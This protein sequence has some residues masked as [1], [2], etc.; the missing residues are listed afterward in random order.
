[1][2]LPVVCRLVDL[3]RDPQTDESLHIGWATYWA[4]SHDKFLVHP[5][6]GVVRPPIY[7]VLLGALI[8]ALGDRPWVILLPNLVIAA[9]TLVVA[10]RLARQLGSAAAGWIAF[11]I[12]ATSWFWNFYVYS[13]FA[14][15][16][17]AL[18]TLLTVLCAVEGRWVRAGIAGAIAVGLKQFGVGTGALAIWLA[19]PVPGSQRPGWPLTR[20]WPDRWR[21]LAR[22]AAGALPLLALI[23]YWEIHGRHYFYAWLHGSPVFVGMNPDNFPVKVLKWARAIGTQ[24]CL[25]PLGIAAGLV[26]AAVIPAQ[27]MILRPL[28]IFV[29]TFVLGISGSTIPVLERYFVWLF[30]LAAVLAACGLVYLS[31]RK[32]WVALAV[33]FLL[34]ARSLVAGPP[35]CPEMIRWGLQEFLASTK[36]AWSPPAR[37]VIPIDVGWEV[38]EQI[39]RSHA[40]TSL[41]YYF[42]SGRADE[43]AGDLARNTHRDVYVLG[44]EGRLLQPECANTWAAWQKTAHRRAWKTF[45]SQTGDRYEL[46]RI[47]AA[48]PAPR[49]DGAGCDPSGG[50]MAQ[51]VDWGF[52]PRLLRI[53]A[54]PEGGTV[55]ITTC[56]T[57][58]KPITENWP[59]Y[60]HV[61]DKDHHLVANLN[62]D[63]VHGTRPTT[64]WKPGAVVTDCMDLEPVEAKAAL[65]KAVTI[66]IGFYDPFLSRRLRLARSKDDDLLV[67]WRDALRR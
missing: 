14:D 17:L 34:G 51:G 24:S 11:W 65:A 7:L 4:W 6:V 45:T 39:T 37:L 23:V 15:P 5:V 32:V 46:V 36:T 35:R 2:A 18:F 8:K 66:S 60:F 61:L 52:G 31:A 57:A 58:W 38:L 55:R 41:G 63:P 49:C 10:F 19:L 25:G 26:A 30:P 3:H 62:Y 47:P 53:E 42:Y 21:R 54:R 1:M 12:L 9:A 44:V 16:G 40:Y 56:W 27:A 43:I 59:M 13:A 33:V 22:V 64:S 29:V 48:S 67:P 20:G 28:L 50:L